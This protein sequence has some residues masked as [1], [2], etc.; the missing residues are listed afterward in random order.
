MKRILTI[1][2]FVMGWG[3]YVSAQ[4]DVYFVPSK[5]VEEKNE[6][7]PQQR[8][9]YPTQRTIVVNETWATED[10]NAD[11]DVDRYNRRGGTEADSVAAEPYEEVEAD[12]PGECTSL[13]VRFHS[14]R[15]GVFVSSPYYYDYLDLWYDPWY[16]W[17]WYGW[18]GPY[19]AWRWGGPWWGFSWGWGPSWAWGPSWGWAPPHYWHPHYPHRGVGPHG[20]YVAYGGRRSSARPSRNFGNVRQT[21]N[22]PSRNYGNSRRQ[23]APSRN[24]GNRPSNS[25]RNTSRPSR[26]FGNS[27][28]S[29]SRSFG[30]SGGGRISAP[31]RNFGGGGGGRSFGGGRG[32]R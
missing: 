29:P 22:R 30:N 16:D 2:L 18:G 24:Y 5:N 19:W 8:V 11:W 9:S 6:A 25:Y 31:S 10:R 21:W 13:I 12:A 15:F 27:G 28:V 32:R 3:T 26:N 20:G 23:F 14:P 7:R 1:M 4:D 17:A